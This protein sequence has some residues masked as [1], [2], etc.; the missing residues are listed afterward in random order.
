MPVFFRF[1]FLFI[2]CI[3]QSSS[4]FAEEDR[5]LSKNDS[6][7]SVYLTWTKDPSTTMTVRWITK[8]DS[9]EDY[10]EYHK[11]S[12]S[13]TIFQEGEHFGLPND[14]E[15]AVH[16]A[17]LEELEPN[18]VYDFYLPGEEKKFSFKTFSSGSSEEPIV[19]VVGGD[20]SAQGIDLF[21]EM[22]KQ[23]ALC[24]PR[25]V[26]FGGDLAYASSSKKTGHDKKRRWLKWLTSYYETM[27]TT[28][29]LLIP[30]LVTIGNHDV[31][32]SFNQT[33][34]E[35]PYYYSLFAMPGLPGYNVV[36]FGDVMS[37]YLL[38]SG[39]TNQVFGKQSQWLESQLKKDKNVLN[40]F[41]IYHVPAYPSVRYQGSTISSLI[42]RYWVP[43]FEKY[44]VHVAFENHDHA[45]KRTYP[46]KNSKIDPNGV[47][48]IGD[49]SWGVR[50]RI[51]K[52]AAMTS[53]FAKTLSR[54][55][56]VKVEITP[57]KRKFWAITNDGVVID[58][59]EQDVQKP[60]KSS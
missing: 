20:T 23:A 41:C 16:Q 26:L 51:P 2:L 19:F 17:E 60:K 49:G 32:G 54:R 39:I 35:A 18:S 57:E 43:I 30:M 12:G 38:D 28:D 3:T 8:K 27:K 15:Y 31:N 58:Q 9:V 42:R 50:P 29:G 11:A 53:F 22:N 40:R 10:V 37:I 7:K 52:K 25:F 44:G 46:L 48:Y 1:V 4:A 55:Q 13:K 59:F 14:S 56:F 24:N 47:L 45:Y 6:I 33:P 34:N 5:F 21:E 36:R